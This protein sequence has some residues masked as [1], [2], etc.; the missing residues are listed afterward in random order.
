VTLSARQRLA[1]TLLPATGYSKYSNSRLRRRKPW[2]A[3][4]CSPA[5]CR[6][7]PSVTG[8]AA[9]R[10]D[11]SPGASTQPTLL[12]APN[13][14][15]LG[16]GTRLSAT[17]S[18]TQ[19]SRIAPPSPA[20]RSTACCTWHTT[21]G[22]ANS[23]FPAFT[24]SHAAEQVPSR[25]TSNSQG[26]SIRRH[27]PAPSPTTC[28]HPVRGEADHGERSTTASWMRGWNV[29][30]GSTAR[31]G[32][33]STEDKQSNSDHSWVSPAPCSRNSHARSARRSALNRLRHRALRSLHAKRRRAAICCASITTPS[34]SRFFIVRGAGLL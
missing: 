6:R 17:S 27:A 21:H 4:S 13:L 20:A 14:S 26:V 25:A 1:S 32:S 24:S 34:G 18:P 10:C 15:S 5:I 7:R 23:T 28:G 3:R 33:R 30:V 22:N 19:S 11:N 9:A 12:T 8:Y 2:I 29:S 16:T 31:S